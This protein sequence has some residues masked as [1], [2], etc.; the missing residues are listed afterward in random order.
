MCFSDRDLVAA[1]PRIYKFAISMVRD[2]TYAEDI[3]QETAIRMIRGRQHYEPR[4]IGLVS[5]GC[6]IAQNY[7]RDEAST[8]RARH[9][10]DQVAGLGSHTTWD[11]PGTGV[12]TKEEP[13]ARIEL[14]DCLDFLS[15]CNG[16][17]QAVLMLALG[18]SHQEIADAQGITVTNVKKRILRT[19]EKLDEHFGINRNGRR[20]ISG[21]RSIKR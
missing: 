3:A 14:K 11:I 4:E 1:Y 19:R 18:D 9:E 2:K 8:L 6:K 16:S 15:N 17:G 5:W 7:Y 10:V 12:V 21:N 13:S 20:G